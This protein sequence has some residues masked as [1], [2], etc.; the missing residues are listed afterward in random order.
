MESLLWDYG[1]K[2]KGKCSC[3]ITQC[4]CTRIQL[5]FWWNVWRNNVFAELIMND[6]FVRYI[7][8]NS[9]LSLPNMTFWAKFLNFKLTCWKLIVAWSIL[10]YNVLKWIYPIALW[11]HSYKT[12]FTTYPSALQPSLFSF[13]T[14]S[15]K[16]SFS[17]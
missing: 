5:V 16:V 14:A 10:E 2:K 3:G 17:R 4:I 11:C 7:W 12:Y 9:L 6:G 15:S 13:T 8:G 1:K